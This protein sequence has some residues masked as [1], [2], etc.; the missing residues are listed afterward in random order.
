M[1]K[2][3]L[4]TQG[5]H[6]SRGARQHEIVRGTLTLARYKWEVGGGAAMSQGWSGWGA[7]CTHGLC[8]PFP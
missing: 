3:F 8:A 5:K 7:E 1:E 4:E 2:Y 6:L